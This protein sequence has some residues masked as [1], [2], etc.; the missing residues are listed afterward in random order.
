MTKYL[1]LLAATGFFLATS[2]SPRIVTQVLKTYPRAE[3]YEQMPIYTDKNEVDPQAEIIGSVF[4]GE[5]GFT[6]NCGYQ[7][8]VHRAVVEARSIGGDA[9]LIVEHIPPSII[10]TCHQ[11][12]AKILKENR[13]LDSA[14]TEI[15][16]PDENSILTIEE[17]IASEA[18]TEPQK[19]K[20]KLRF[21]IHG[22]W[23]K[24]TTDPPPDISEAYSDYLQN[25]ESGY[26]IGG[27]MMWQTGAYF[28]IGLKYIFNKYKNSGEFIVPDDMGQPLFFTL[29]DNLK[30]HFLGTS[31]NFIYPV[32]S[33]GNEW[34]MGCSLGYLGLRNN[35]VV[36]DPVKISGDSF[37]V[38]FDIGYN[39]MIKEKLGLGLQMSV[40]GG[41]FNK[42]EYDYG[43]R[44]EVIEFDD[45]VKEGLSRL[46]F[47]VALRF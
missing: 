28:G 29:S 27:E 40:V 15:V 33:N 30:Y 23:S 46:D 7:N 42:L 36:M 12:R 6:T 10:S 22:G 5:S 35:A 41:G 45:E 13:L 4:V 24:V 16:F 34:V 47:S 20:K 43:S 18:I 3:E 37:G 17:A 2:C 44:V 25:L 21:S 1:T 9:I 8:M 31:F 19:F 14:Y 26:H 38:T 11:I 39:F 32:K